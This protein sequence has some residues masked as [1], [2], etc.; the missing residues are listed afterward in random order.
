MGDT[1]RRIGFVNMLTTGTGG[2]KG[3]DANIGRIDVNFVDLVDF[4]QDRDGTGRSMNTALRF[5]LWYSLYAVR[6]RFEFSRE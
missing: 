6:T 2:A 5:C 4:W 1:N 3:I